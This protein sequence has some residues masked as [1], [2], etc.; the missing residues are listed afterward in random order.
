M[1][2]SADGS[3]SRYRSEAPPDAVFECRGREIYRRLTPRIVLIRLLAEAEISSADCESA[4]LLQKSR[5]RSCRPPIAARL[6]PTDTSSRP[7]A[8]RAPAHE[9]PIHPPHTPLTPP[10]EKPTTDRAPKPPWPTTPPARAA[11]RTHPRSSTDP[12]PHDTP[13]PPP[14]GIETGLRLTRQHT[15]RLEYSPTLAVRP[16]T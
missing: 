6:I 11:T 4:I 1:H 13:A 16:P 15:Q 7:P 10:Y 5:S 8:A 2:V 3:Q 14:Q 9:R 12:D